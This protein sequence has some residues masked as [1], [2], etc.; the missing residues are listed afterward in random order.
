MA[1]VLF[2]LNNITIAFLVCQDMFETFCEKKKRYT[3]MCLVFEYKVS[4]V[5]TG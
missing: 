5:H 2:S 4:S 3:G 1:V